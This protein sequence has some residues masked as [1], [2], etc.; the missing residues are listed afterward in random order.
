MADEP[1]NRSLQQS[2]SPAPR[3]R[4][5]ALLPAALPLVAL[6]A[7]SLIT[8]NPLVPGVNPAPSAA[9][10]PAVAGSPAPVPLLATNHPVDWWVAYKFNSSSFPG[11]DADPGR[12][13][14]FGGTVQHG[15][16]SQKYAVAS[17]INPVL[18]DG[19]G[20]IGSSP[21]DPLGATFA[22][23]YNGKYRFVTWNDQFYGDPA[24]KAAH[25]DGQQCGS[26]WGHSKGILA[27]NDA[28]VGMV[29]QVTTPSWPG[30]GSASHPRKDG[31]TLG[32]VTDN[33]IENAQDFFALRLNRDDVKV[34]L[35]ALAMASVSTDVANAQIV[36]SGADGTRPADDID[37][38]VV[39]LGRI[40]K[41]KTYLD[42]QLSSGVRLIA[43]PSELHVPPWQFVSSVLGGEPLLTA[44]WW[45]YPTITSTR[46]AADVHCWDA[47]LP[48]P[49]GEVDVALAGTWNTVPVTF[50]GGPNHA[51]IGVSLPGSQHRYAIFGDLNQQGQ[52]GGTAS[53]R[54]DSS[55]NGRGGMFFVIDNAALANGIAPL[56]TGKIAPFPAG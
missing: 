30:A 35:H 18:T 2:P 38:L 56:L 55:Q 7:I 33:N 28:G 17:S 1:Q 36:Q 3:S 24:R 40:S 52:L 15:S 39:S 4:S 47:S 19:P 54:C 21:A 12:G 23:I 53:S 11:N 10:A 51:K 43:K 32:C 27:W 41:E 45:A 29:L 46:N 8:G 49:P 50:T 20:L 13:C 44:T 5:T 25:C 26:P 37:T 16:Y 34:V 42:A 6:G 48:T 9:T 14:A 22:Q 31:N